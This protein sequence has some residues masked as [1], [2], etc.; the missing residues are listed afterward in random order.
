VTDPQKPGLDPATVLALL[1]FL[2]TAAPELIKD[3]EALI[4]DFKNAPAPPADLEQE[5]KDTTQAN[6]D[7][8]QATL[9]APQPGT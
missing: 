2:F 8:L 5:V 1:T 7:A 9:P 6:L 3:V 4:A